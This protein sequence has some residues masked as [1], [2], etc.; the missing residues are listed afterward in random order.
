MISVS[1]DFNALASGP[2]RPLDYEAAVSFT[3]ARNQ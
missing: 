1:N 2:V 3:K